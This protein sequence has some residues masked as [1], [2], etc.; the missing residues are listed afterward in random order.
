M[1]DRD[2]RRILRELAAGAATALAVG[3]VVIMAL[4]AVAATLGVAVRIFLSASRL[5]S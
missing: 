5:G 3:C 1:I 4:F 2:D